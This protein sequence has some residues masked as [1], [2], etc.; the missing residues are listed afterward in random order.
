MEEEHAVL[1]LNVTEVKRMLTV[2]VQR[3]KADR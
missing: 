3:L 1:A 2:F